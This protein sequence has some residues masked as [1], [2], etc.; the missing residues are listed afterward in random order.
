MQLVTLA[1]EIIG[2]SL[3][4]GVAEN[5]AGTFQYGLLP[6]GNLHR[7]HVEILGD[8]LDSFYALESFERHPGLEFRLVSASFRFHF[9][10]VQL[11]VN[12]RPQP[13]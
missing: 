2:S 12:I 5:S 9:C 7:V 10:V 1:L 11:R 3:R 4:T 13:P 8:L 6:I